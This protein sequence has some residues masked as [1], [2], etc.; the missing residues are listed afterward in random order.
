M[1]K[2]N[3]VENAEQFITEQI[4]WA[5]ANRYEDFTIWSNGEELHACIDTVE[6]KKDIA[7]VFRNAD[8]KRNGFWK[9]IIYR[10]GCRVEI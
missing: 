7:E 5:K 3:S 1:K 9:A 2:Y 10:S 4:A 8:L 6:G